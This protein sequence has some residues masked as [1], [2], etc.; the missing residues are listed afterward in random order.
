M[1]FQPGQIVEFI[2]GGRIV[3][4]I[5]LEDRKGRV[6]LLTES[7]REI[8]MAPGR[9]VHVSEARSSLNQ[10]RDA[11]VRKL[12]ERATAREGLARQI[13]VTA[14]WELLHQEGG[15]YAPLELA[16][17]AFGGRVNDDHASAVIRAMLQDRVYFRFRADAFRPNEAETVEKILTQR[18]REEEKERQIREGS[19]WVRSLWDG[20]ETP[21]PDGWEGILELLKEHAVHGKAAARAQRSEELLRRAGMSHP[22][23]A[24]Q[25]LVKLGVWS[26]DE[27]IL[28]HRF[29]TRRS[30]P[31]QLIHEVR[32]L[33]ERTVFSPGE[34]ASREDLLELLTFTIDSPHTRD[35]DDAL[36]LESL[37]E[38][39]YR[40]GIHIADVSHVVAVGSPLDQEAAL[41]GTSLYL[42]D[43]RISMFPTEVSEDLSSL[44]EGEIR[45]AVS[46]LMEVDAQGGVLQHR[47]SLSWI[48]VKQRLSYED[49]DRGMEDPGQAVGAL[50]RMAKAWREERAR[51]GALLL[52]LPEVTV[53]VEEEGALCLEQR[54]RESPSQILVSEMMIQANWLAARWLRSSGTP[55]IY[56][57]QTEPRERI[58]EGR[59]GDLFL[60]YRQRKLLSRAGFDLEPAVHHGL[61]VEVYTTVTS[62]IRRFQDLVMQRQMASLIR[63][64]PP[65]YGREELERILA[66]SEELLSQAAQLEQ[67]RQ[68]YWLLKHLDTRKGEETSALVLGR[69]G[70]RVQLLLTAYMIEA[71]LPAASAGWLQE[72]QEVTVRILR[73]KPQEDELRIELR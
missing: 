5:C 16:E 8:T 57:S 56:R 48:R 39:Q 72:G 50:F 26:P 42:P 12:G 14:L 52:P 21:R 10:P 73:A 30:F 40:V 60:N 3:V 1:V 55:S 53:R 11:L 17:L 66:E 36:S 71:S 2:E 38:G 35:I 24:F 32:D 70:R 54:D 29:G 37:G 6:R 69:Y 31:P 41:R 59:E 9:L 67:T 19:Q 20:Q 51:R 58:L 7:Q 28:L 62:P 13:D 22:L 45:P 15:E 49:T 4:A 64:G 63:G 43:E 34:T 65:P 47:F 25:V 23:A 68:R 46:L 33:R 61:G 44:R 18:A 27:N